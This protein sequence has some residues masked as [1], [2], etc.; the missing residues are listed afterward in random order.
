TASGRF[1]RRFEE[2]LFILFDC[3]FAAVCY[4]ILVRGWCSILVGVNILEDGPK[5]PFAG[6]S[7]KSLVPAAGAQPGV[8]AGG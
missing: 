1:S 2:R 3:S 7:M 4:N 8:G 6:T 5:N